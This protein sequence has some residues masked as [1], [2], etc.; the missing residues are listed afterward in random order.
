MRKAHF[1]DD[2]EAFLEPMPIQFAKQQTGLVSA[3]PVCC[4]V[5]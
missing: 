5:G 1:G 2:T 4:Y 3:S